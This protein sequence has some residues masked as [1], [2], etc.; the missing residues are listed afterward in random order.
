MFH[1][2]KK[3]VAVLATGAAMALTAGI[4]YAYFTASGSGTGAATVGSASAIQLS[5]DSVS[6]LYPGAADTA[7]TVH[8]T[9]AGSSAQYVDT[10]SG[11]VADSGSCLGSWF[12]VDSINYASTLAA[13][14]SDDTSTVIRMLESGTNQD[15][16]QGA[17]L[18][19]NWLSN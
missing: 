17:S 1:F 14:A 9:N 7:V 10:I 15:A 6:D 18:T 19:I 12:E 4:A 16:C 8:V 2:T 3:K 5:S 13:G 11:T